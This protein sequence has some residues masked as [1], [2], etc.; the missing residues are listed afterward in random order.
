MS[1]KLAL[2]ALGSGVF[3]L[4]VERIVHIL[5]A[6]KPFALPL[7]RPS[8]VGAL[9]DRDEVVPVFDSATCLAAG[10]DADRV[11]LHVIYEAEIGR[12]ALPAGRVL[13]MVESGQGTLRA[14]A[15]ESSAACKQ[16]F[17]FQG[18]EFPLLDVDEL[19]VPPSEA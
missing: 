4:P 13:Q 8:I 5:A 19:F 12:V 1:D 2:F 3:A 11:A 17:F 6:G 18:R 14:P 15:V 7:L 9:V 10:T 16:V